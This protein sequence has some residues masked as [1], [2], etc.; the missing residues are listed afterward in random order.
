M[1]VNLCKANR[2]KYQSGLHLDCLFTCLVLSC[3]PCSIRIDKKYLHCHS[4]KPT[5]CKYFLFIIS[6]LHSIEFITIWNHYDRDGSGYLDLNEFDSF[7]RD[8]LVQKKGASLL[9]F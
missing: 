1:P 8:L 7:I 5:F 9:F 2:V 6:Q 4:S 3:S